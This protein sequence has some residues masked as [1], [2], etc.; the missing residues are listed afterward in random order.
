MAHIIGP[1]PSP[2]DH[3]AVLAWTGRILSVLAAHPTDPALLAAVGDLHRRLKAGGPTPDWVVRGTMEM[4][5]AWVGKYEWISDPHE[6]EHEHERGPRRHGP[7]DVGRH[8]IFVNRRREFP[9]WESYDGDFGA[10][11]D[12]LKDTTGVPLGLDPAVYELAL[13]ALDCDDAQLD[14]ARERSPASK[15]HLARLVREFDLR[16]NALIKT[17]ISTRYNWTVAPKEDLSHL[18]PH[19]HRQ[20]AHAHQHESFLPPPSHIDG[21]G[22]SSSEGQSDGYGS[23]FNTSTGGPESGVL[24]C[25]MGAHSL[26][27]RTAMIHA[28]DRDA[29]IARANRSRW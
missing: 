24:T 12:A 15:A 7:P 5:R 20:Q 2:S 1:A 11:A 22:L 23:Y 19:R 21:G 17:I 6:H 3:G 14:D 8:G 28:L 4:V 25:S 18:L 10:F 13:L 16:R 29:F 9:N 27:R 26:G